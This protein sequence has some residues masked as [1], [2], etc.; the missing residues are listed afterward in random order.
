MSLI[1]QKLSVQYGLKNALELGPLTFEKGQVIALLGPNGSGK[2]SFMKALARQI[3]ALT[4]VF[5]D[6][7]PLAQEQI[8][9]M[10]QEMGAAPMLRVFEM[11]LLGRVKSLKTTVSTQDWQAV[12]AIIDQLGIQNLTQ[13][14]MNELSGG[15]KQLVFLA[16]ALV[17]QPEV[18]LL[19]EPMSALDVKNQFQV[20]SLIKEQTR[21]RQLITFIILHDFNLAS[22]F[23]DECILLKQ[24]QVIATGGLAELHNLSPIETTF[25]VHA[26][27]FY[28]KTGQQCIQAIG[29]KT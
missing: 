12:Q 14:M 20:M 18:L 3:K 15:Q 2:S 9:Y 21:Q 1:I 23:C 22:Q 8:S 4:E 27:W 17:A 26:Q 28:A 11:I 24:G 5:L 25:D 13:Q 16:Q 19:D 29:V 6:T 10:P 7:K